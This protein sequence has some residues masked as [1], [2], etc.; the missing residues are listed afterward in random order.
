[1]N[2][3]E[4]YQKC[5]KI[6]DSTSKIFDD[7]LASQNELIEKREKVENTYGTA[8][9]LGIVAESVITALLVAGIRLVGSIPIALLGVYILSLVILA[10]YSCIYCYKLSKIHK[11]GLDDSELTKAAAIKSKKVFLLSLLAN[12]NNM[13]ALTLQYKDSDEW[14]PENQATITSEMLKTHDIIE[15]EL[16]SL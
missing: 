8:V 4:L 16:A 1:M 9:R 2:T 6:F 7:L 13:L 5:L 15:K 11:R 3:S 14:K 12:T 10:V